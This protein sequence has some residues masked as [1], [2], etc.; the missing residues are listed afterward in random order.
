MTIQ[1][2]RTTDYALL[3]G[4]IAMALIFLVSGWEK[5]TGYAAARQY[6][7]SMGGIPALLPLLVMI[8]IGGGVAILLGA[9]TSWFAYGLACYALL[10]G[11]L[12]HADIADPAEHLHFL[13]NLAIAGGFLI[14]A[15]HGPGVMSVDYFV[16]LLRR[17]VPR[18]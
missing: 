13:K 14:L 16:A 4:R 17:K 18:A 3:V 7:A 6:M 1:L 12:Y 10:A 15:A 9:K 5:A 11:L 8:E 2:F